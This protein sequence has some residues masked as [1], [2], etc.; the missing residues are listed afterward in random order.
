V[1]DQHAADERVRLEALQKIPAT[2][3]FLEHASIHA[4]AHEVRLMQRFQE[5]IEE[6]GFQL[7]TPSET[8]VLASTGGCVG[9]LACNCLPSWKRDLISFVPESWRCH[10]WPHCKCSGATRCRQKISRS[11]WCSSSKRTAPMARRR[12]P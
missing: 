5:Q 1:L 4:T 12:E 2:V 3:E 7:A 9:V 11:S 8:E 6:W 10:S